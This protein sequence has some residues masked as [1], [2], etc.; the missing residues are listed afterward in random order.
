M[1]I[2]RFASNRAI[3][4]G[5]LKG[6]EITAMEG[7]PFTYL[8]RPGGFPPLTDKIYSL[9]D[10]RLLAPCL[11]SKIVA[12]GLNYRKH[13]QER[14]VPIPD[15]PLIF[16]KPSTSV[17]GTEGK[18]VY[19]RA[20]T[21]VDYEGE[22]AVVIGRKAKAIDRAGAK[23]YI[24]GYAC[25]NDVSARQEM[26]DDAGQ[27]SRSK[28]YDTFAPRGPWIDTDVSPDNLKIETYLNGEVVQS[29]RT[30]DLIFPVDLLVSFISSVM[31]L[32]PGDVIS[33]GTPSGTGTPEGPGAMKPGDVVEVRIE[34]IGTLRN[35]I[36]E[37]K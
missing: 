10:V 37:E 17:I 35:Y 23:E 14:N 11:P 16:L 20:S 21:R 4:Y 3:K 28:S 9:K 19:P 29:A 6:D 8:R 2:V 12:V 7:S 34:G 25:L 22:L 30:N 18:I 26:A 36:V 15:H 33:T 5:V 31:T 24:L 13:A 27:V 32:L 1:K